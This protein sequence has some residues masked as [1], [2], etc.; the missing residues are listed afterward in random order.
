[1]APT[2]TLPVGT[3]A[4][5]AIPHFTEW[6]CGHCW[7]AVETKVRQARSDVSPRGHAR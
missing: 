1:M 6:R 2:M 5:N 3:G 7:T 4:E